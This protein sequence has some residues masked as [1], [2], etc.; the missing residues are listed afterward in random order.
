MDTNLNHLTIKKQS[1]RNLSKTAE[2]YPINFEGSKEKFFQNQSKSADFYRKLRSVVA[3]DSLK[4]VVIDTVKASLAK[5]DTV[6][7]EI[8]DLK[9][10]KP[11]VF[12]EQ[13][14]VTSTLS[15]NQQLSSKGWIDQILESTPIILFISSLL[16]IIIVFLVLFLLYRKQGSNT[17]YRSQKDIEILSELCTRFGIKENPND[18][19]Q[20]IN[21]I[22]RLWEG[23]RKINQELTKKQ[24]SQDMEI[25]NLGKE[26]ADAEDKLRKREAEKKNLELEMEV[27]RGQLNKKQNDFEELDSTIKDIKELSEKIVNRYYMQMVLKLERKEVKEDI[28]QFIIKNVFTLAFHSASLSKKLINDDSSY[29]KLNVDLLRGQQHSIQGVVTENTQFEHCDS[30]AY[31]VFRLLK[32]KGI[33]KLDDVTIHGYKI[34]E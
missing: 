17:G 7:L 28:D 13:N 6:V 16:V 18:P 22:H 15:L 19:K 21:E 24:E 29:D 2:V 23:K 10:D 32:D 30:L 4:K 20:T 3:G 8:A 9:H 27:L 34:G 31:Y 25:K 14:K 1:L 26:K 11:E 33:S 5:R 12:E